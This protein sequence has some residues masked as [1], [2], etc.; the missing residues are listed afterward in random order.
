MDIDILDTEPTDQWD[1]VDYTSAVIGWMYFLAW[2]ASFYPQVFLNYDKKRYASSFLTAYLIICM[3][4]VQ[5]GWFLI[6]I[7]SVEP[8]WILFLLSLFSRRQSQR[9]PRYW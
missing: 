2:S 1:A 4:F 9:R 7:R 8:K 3:T 5:C 6:R